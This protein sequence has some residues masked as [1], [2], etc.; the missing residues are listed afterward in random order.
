VTTN[1]LRQL[2]QLKN[3]YVSQL[4]NKI[5]A[6]ESAWQDYLQQPNH[7][8]LQVLYRQAHDLSGSAGTYGYK[9]LNDVARRIDRLLR[10]KLDYERKARITALIKQLSVISTKIK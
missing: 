7:E 2:H 5:A 4:P 6:M 1:K 3:Y 9:E 10:E 8:L